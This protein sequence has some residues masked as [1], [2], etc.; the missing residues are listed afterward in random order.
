MRAVSIVIISKLRTQQVLFCTDARKERQN[1]QHC[2]KHTDSRTK[3]QAPSQRVHEEAKIT[4]VTDNSVNT[5][6]HQSVSRL[7]RD[8][9][10]ESVA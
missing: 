10:A 1:K 2:E 7:D 4:G 6:G 3:S 8:E 5:T 9:A